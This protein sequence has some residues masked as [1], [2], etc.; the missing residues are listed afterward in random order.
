[1]AYD[2]ARRVTVLFGGSTDWTVD[3]DQ[4]WE[5]NGATWTQRIAS[6][7]SARAGH[8]MT[9]DLAR[10]VTVLFGGYDLN[11]DLGD[12][13][14]WNGNAWTE[15]AV[16]GPLPRSGHAMVYD[17]ARAGTLLFGATFDGETWGL[18]TSCYPNCDGSTT[19]P[20]LNV[21]DYVCFMN[22]FLAAQGLPSELQVVN[23]VNCDRSTA[24]P[25]LNIADFVCF[26][27]RF[28]AG[29]Q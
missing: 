26:Q 12:T 3:D 4:T 9:Y 28:V 6:G 8:S 19:A 11:T 2:A 21:S 25:V 17:R 13:W 29:C 14:E 24:A 15:Q 27:A 18:R 5:W 10:G 16:S 23:Y 20:V 22:R 7:P 1:M